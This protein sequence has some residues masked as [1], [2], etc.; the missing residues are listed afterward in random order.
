MKPDD[1]SQEAWDAAFLPSEYVDA[2]DRRYHGAKAI[3][4]AEAR[5]REACAQVAEDKDGFIKQGWGHD[6]AAR[7]RHEV[8]A[9][10]RNRARP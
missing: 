8:A 4:A 9:A 6:A 1:I 5:E 3:M 7:A 2:I 10:I